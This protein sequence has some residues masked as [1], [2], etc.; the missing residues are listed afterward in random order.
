LFYNCMKM[1]AN[2]ISANHTRFEKVQ[3]F[4]GRV[5]VG[6]RVLRALVVAA[7]AVLDQRRLRLRP[8]NKNIKDYL[9]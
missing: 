2:T 1:F 6:L 7:R 8:E 5:R 9:F 4:V 3:I